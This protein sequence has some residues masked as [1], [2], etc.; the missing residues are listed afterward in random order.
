MLFR[1]NFLSHSL[2]LPFPYYWDCFLKLSS[3]IVKSAN[4][5]NCMGKIW[6]KCNI[7]IGLGLR[8]WIISTPVEWCRWVKYC[9]V[10]TLRFENVRLFNFNYIIKLIC[11]QLV[12]TN[13]LH[14]LSTILDSSLL[15]WWFELI[16]WDCILR[17]IIY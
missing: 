17:N 13:C 16:T 14:M 12:I 7:Y 3:V 5:N 8:N 2:A 11:Y 9:S 4:C 15:V 1:R 6:S 10:C